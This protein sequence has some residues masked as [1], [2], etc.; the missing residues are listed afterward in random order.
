M[1]RRIENSKIV[2]FIENTF[3]GGLIGMAFAL[4]IP[5]ILAIMIYLAM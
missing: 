4:A 1:I 5:G 3:I 2:W